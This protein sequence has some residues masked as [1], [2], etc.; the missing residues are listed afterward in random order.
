MSKTVGATSRQDAA[1]AEYLAAQLTPEEKAAA[2]AE[3]ERAVGEV[4]GDTYALLLELVGKEDL[5]YYDL[6]ELREDRD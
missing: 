5:E 6:D 3:A 1:W 4:P 2:R